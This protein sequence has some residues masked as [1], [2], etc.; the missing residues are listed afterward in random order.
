MYKMTDTKLLEKKIV[1]NNSK[2]KILTKHGK[3]K[4]PN[5][6]NQKCRIIRSVDQ[7]SNHYMCAAVRPKQCL[8]LTKK[9]AGT[10]G[11]VKNKIIIL[12]TPSEY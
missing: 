9:N 4:S 1:E 6:W 8:N 10:V 5:G 12:N 11:Y 3:R 7:K 2:K